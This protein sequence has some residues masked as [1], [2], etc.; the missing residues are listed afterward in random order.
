MLSKVGPGMLYQNY[1]MKNVIGLDWLLDVFVFC[2]IIHLIAN[3][4]TPRGSVCYSFR[5]HV[6]L[7]KFELRQSDPV[8]IIYS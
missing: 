1:L 7:H 8:L 4:V 3:P 5:K 6:W 2:S